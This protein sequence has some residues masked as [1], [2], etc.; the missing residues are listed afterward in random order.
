[1]NNLVTIQ[2]VRAYLDE[3]GTAMLN[4]DDTARGLGMVKVDIKGANVYTRINKQVIGNLL[5]TFGILTSEELPEFIPEDAFYFLAI[6]ANNQIAVDFQTTVCKDILPAIRKHGAY[7]TADTIEKT[8]T[9][10]DFIIGLAMRLKDEQR[11]RR[12]AENTVSL[13]THTGKTY[14]STELAKELGFKSAIALNKWLNAHSIIFKQNGT[15]LPYSK[16][17]DLGYVSI[18]QSIL[19]NGIVTYNSRWT[20]TGREFLLKLKDKLEVA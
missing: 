11:L 16:Y 5:K 17:S 4:L 2:G 1:M 15:W 6:K 13:L 7:M 8:L 20:M 19:D 12:D 10:P 3:Q 9:D 14:T 18:K